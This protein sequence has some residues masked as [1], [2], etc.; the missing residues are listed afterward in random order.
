MGITCRASRRASKKEEFAETD[1]GILDQCRGM[2]VAVMVESSPTVLPTFRGPDGEL[3][4]AVCSFVGDL[5]CCRQE[6]V[7]IALK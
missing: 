5:D 7:S 1:G 3:D 4:V 6:R 2:I